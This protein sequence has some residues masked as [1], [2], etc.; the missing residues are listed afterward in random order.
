MEMAT[1]KPKGYKGKQPY[2]SKPQFAKSR[3]KTYQNPNR[4]D[5]KPMQGNQSGGSNQQ[6]RQNVKI[7]PEMR[8]CY[9]YGRKGHLANS[10][11]T[12]EYFVNIYKELQQLKAR[13]PEA[14]ALD[15]PT[16]AANENYMVNG[17]TPALAINSGF[18]SNLNIDGKGTSLRES[19][20]A[21][22]SQELA[23]LNSATTHTILW[24]SLYFSFTG[25]DTDIWQVCQMQTIAGGRDFKFREGRATIVLPGGATLLIA[26]AIFAPS[27]SQSLISFKDLRA[28]DIHTMTIV[29]NNKEALLL[30]RETE[31]LATAYAGCGGLYELPIRSGGQ[32][33]K[34][35]LASEP[36]KPQSFALT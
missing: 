19:W 1:R 25:S 32:P 16:L 11:R 20:L 8:S 15:A 12:P 18:A 31:V 36:T 29:K 23:L 2:N 5:S 35:S 33:H 24:D 17:P 14:H 30:Q 21:H 4:T 22:N 28:N 3:N 26:N 34:V 27:A 9:K 10:C 6:R 13:Q 7:G